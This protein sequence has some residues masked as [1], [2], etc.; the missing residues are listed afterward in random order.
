MF[1]NKGLDAFNMVTLSGAH[2]I[3]RSHCT[4]FSTDRLPPSNTL[5]MDPAFATKL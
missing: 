3:G 1:A 5:D 2:S 4:S